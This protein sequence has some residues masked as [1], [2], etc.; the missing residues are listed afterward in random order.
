MKSYKFNWSNPSTLNIPVFQNNISSCIE[1]DTSN[2]FAKVCKKEPGFVLS[3]VDP[4]TE[5]QVNITAVNGAGR[6]KTATVK[7]PGMLVYTHYKLQSEYLD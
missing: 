7:L 3:Q 2:S 1:I 6:G 5:Y 4:A